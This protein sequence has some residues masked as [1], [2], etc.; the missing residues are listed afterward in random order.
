MTT[1]PQA[2]PEAELIRCK[3]EAPPRMSKRRAASLIGISEGWWRQLEAGGRWYRGRW[4]PQAGSAATIARMARA[5][6]VT[7][8]ELDDAG[9]G[10]AAAEFRAAEPATPR[11][12]STVPAGTMEELRAAVRRVEEIAAR[13]EGQ[14]K[15]PDDGGQQGAG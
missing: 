7:A 6:G 15:P 14:R 13:I 8:E 3:R 5:V 1:T 9:R 11:E 12:D 10:D 4:E 2:P